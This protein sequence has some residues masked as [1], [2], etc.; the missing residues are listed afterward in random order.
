[1]VKVKRLVAANPRTSGFIVAFGDSLTNTPSSLRRVLFGPGSIDTN[2][3]EMFVLERLANATMPDETV[4]ARVSARMVDLIPV[5]IDSLTTAG[6]V[7]GAT[8]LAVAPGGS[9]PCTGAGFVW[10]NELFGPLKGR[11]IMVQIKGD[12]IRDE[13]KRA[14]D[15]NFLLGTLPTGDGIAGG[16]FWSYFVLSGA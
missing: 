16:T 5:N 10:D 12:F 15:A 4:W 2:T 1:L 13:K 14:V 9:V 7:T 6:S 11:T 8:E 3:F